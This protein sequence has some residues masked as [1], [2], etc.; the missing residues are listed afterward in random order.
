MNTCT[1][2]AV[3]LSAASKTW[4]LQRPHTC[5]ASPVNN[6]EAYLLGTVR[7]ASPELAAAYD[8]ALATANKNQMKGLRGAELERKISDT[9]H[10]RRV[11]TD[12]TTNETL[13]SLYESGFTRRFRPIRRA[14]SA[15][16]AKTASSRPIRS[17]S[18]TRHGAAPSEAGCRS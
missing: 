16:T 8:D 9:L 3:T 17:R 2:T 15:L 12:E 1:G 4:R 14:A 13:A 7:W 10:N 11:E 5:R 6:L 18:T